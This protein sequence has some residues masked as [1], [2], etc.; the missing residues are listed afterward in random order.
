MDN[1]VLGIDVWE[2]DA[3]SI[4]YAAIK[5]NGVGFVSVRLNDMNGGHHTDTSFA[6]TWPKVTAAG[7]LRFPY[8]VYNPWVNSTA[9]YNW[10]LAN[11][12]S[13]ATAVALDVEVRYTGITASQ[14]AADI[15][16]LVNLSS[17]KW[18]TFIYTGYGYYDML[19]S[20]PTTCD[21]WIAQYPSGFWY[22]SQTTTWATVKTQTTSVVWPP[23]NARY[24]LPGA[25]KIWQI[26]GDRLK[27]LPGCP[28]VID[29]NIW[30][31]SL[32][33]M[34]AWLGTNTAPLPTRDECIDDMLKK[35][36]YT[37]K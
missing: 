28:N 12:P 25:T 9:N 2:G 14:Y 15:A 3:A 18:K 37:W 16:N 29:I 31:G 24:Y 1:Y 11:M 8:F 13:D 30:N 10:L 6:A 36:G 5:A 20:W 33:D 19:S 17:K 21:Y 27:V 22:T 4:D 32:T 34:T 23:Y 35:H 7:L 26:S